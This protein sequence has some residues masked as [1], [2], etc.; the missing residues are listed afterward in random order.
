MS[1]AKLIGVLFAIVGAMTLLAILFFTGYLGFNYPTNSRYPV[2]GIDVSHHQGE[3]VWDELATGNVSFVYMKATEGADHQ[4]RRFHE[5]WAAAGAA[6]IPRGAYHFFTF[7]TP[8]SAQAENFLNTV[9]QAAT[10]LP[11]AIDIE[12][13]GNCK[14][15]SS[16]DEIRAELQAFVKRVEQASGNRPVLYVTERGYEVVAG[17][18]PGHDLWMRSIF[19]KPRP[20]SGRPWT[21]WQFTDRGR[22]PGIEGFVDLNVFNGTATDFEVLLERSAAESFAR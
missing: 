13:S 18:F 21:F 8:G 15:W 1:K 6:G 3:I 7:C 9:P 5:N 10:S 2:R 11:P 22:R 12:F 4:D 20:R 19:Q 14:N 17:H 16:L